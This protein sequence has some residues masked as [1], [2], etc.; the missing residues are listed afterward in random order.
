MRARERDG[1]ERRRTLRKSNH[2]KARGKEGGG[3]GAASIPCTFLNFFEKTTATATA[4]AT[5]TR[6]SKSDM[7]ISKT[8]ISHV[9]HSLSPF[10]GSCTTMTLKIFLLKIPRFD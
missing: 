1:N 3:G 5:A 2:N 7:L 4:T 9:E 8:T 6:T 10:P